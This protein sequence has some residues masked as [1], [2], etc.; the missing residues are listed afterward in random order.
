MSPDQDT[1]DIIDSAAGA[2]KSAAE[3]TAAWT[4]DAAGPAE[5]ADRL[6]TV[7]QESKNAVDAAAAGAKDAGGDA[8][9]VAKKAKDA[10]AE[11]ARGGY[12]RAQQFGA[13]IA[14]RTQD[15]PLLAIATAFTA[16]LVIGFA[17]SAMLKP[18]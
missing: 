4:A 7:V 17:L 13:D 1:S 5:L 2:A 12:E 11:A 6:E 14:T 15:Q 18:R 16:G 9:E 8:W 10:T 3:A